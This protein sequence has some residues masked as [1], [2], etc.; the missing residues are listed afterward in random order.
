MLCS[1]FSVFEFQ[2]DKDGQQAN[3]PT[4]ILRENDGHRIKD[5]GKPRCAH[6]VFSD[7]VRMNNG[8][9][10]AKFIEKNHLGELFKSPETVNPNSGN[11]IETWIWTPDW[12]AMKNL[13]VKHDEQKTLYEEK[14]KE[15]EKS[16]TGG[17]YV[18]IVLR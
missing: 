15:K 4:A 10:L 14:K 13:V 12:A 17:L 2:F 5:S 3:P 6:I 7:S 16:N 9:S 18:D 11:R 1:K 8:R